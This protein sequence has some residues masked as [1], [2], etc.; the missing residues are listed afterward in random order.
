MPMPSAMNRSHPRRRSAPLP[1]RFAN[2][3]LRCVRGSLAAVGL[4]GLA[5]LGGCGDAGLGESRDA[6]RQ[7][8]EA[9]VSLEQIRTARINAPASDA[10]LLEARDA[11]TLAQLSELAVR[12][13]AVPGDARDKGPSQMLLAEVYSTA[14]DVAAK[15]FERQSLR[16]AALRRQIVQAA[17]AASRLAALAASLERADPPSDLAMLQR[18]QQTRVAAAESLRREMREARLAAS[19]ERRGA[20]ESLASAEIEFEQAELARVEASRSR[21]EDQRNLIAETREFLR[22]AGRFQSEAEIDE[23][24]A[25]IREA[26]AATLERQASGAELVA[27][28]ATLAASQAA[29]AAEAWRAEGRALASD[30][31]S[32][33][34]E[35]DRDLASLPSEEGDV[36]DVVR[37]FEQA[38]STAERAAASDPAAAA[39]ARLLAAA[40]LQGW[41]QFLLAATNRLDAE[42][43][44]LAVLA[45]LREPPSQ[46][47]F[48]QS[49]LAVVAERRAETIE[50]ARTRLG[51]A[52]ERLEAVSD[53]DAVA[54]SLRAAAIANIAKAA[55]IDRTAPATMNDSRGGA[56]PM[57]EAPA[58][59]GPP[60]STPESLLLYL[61]AIEWGRAA[62]LPPTQLMAATSPGGRQMLRAMDRFA[63]AMEP[64][65]AAMRSAFGP[66]ATA[67]ANE[68]MAAMAG[69]NA[70]GMISGWASAVLVEQDGDSAL[71]E[72]GGTQV[73]LLSQGGE[74]RVDYDAMLEGSGVDPGSL[75]ML[76][77]MMEGMAG[78]LGTFLRMFSQRIEDGEFG[79][80]DEALAAMQQEM[81]SAMGGGM[82]GGRGF[83]R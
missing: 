39:S 24:R 80:A 73:P 32:I 67:A 82:G 78:Q 3:R 19:S 62:S 18:L 2:G 57:A 46:T 50:Q 42:A 21:G 64:V 65:D 7:V 83:G 15:R 72:V 68:S 81:M 66:E 30:L 14:G 5:L 71:V 29:A 37:Q 53:G 56:A 43:A 13:A 59:S 38:V 75:P 12:L 35:L 20:E 26:E 47:A 74:W 55:G 16:E 70:M 6:S 41:G 33:R 44:M 34:Q 54:A 8:G 9:I 77:G 51:E 4:A 63:E 45:E 36:D 58:P 27:E 61:A 23:L 28:S 40:A 17:A 10:E 25:I 22:E 48:L 11:A 76:A 31:S 69:G 60:F 1:D 79:S 49:R 52:I